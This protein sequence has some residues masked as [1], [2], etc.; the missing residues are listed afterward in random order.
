MY[1]TKF[2]AF[3][4]LI[5]LLSLPFLLLSQNNYV[6]NPSFDEISDCDLEFG[7]VP[8]AEPW[9]IVEEPG[10]SP[11]LYHAC[12]TNTFYDLP[13]FGSCYDVYPHSG[14]GMAA[15][16]HIAFN[17][18]IYVR[19]SDELPTGID[20]YVAFHTIPTHR[21]GAETICY[22]NTQCLAF[23]DIAF[24]DRRVALQM[25]TILD[26]ADG[27]TKVDGCYQANGKEKLLLIGNYKLGSETLVDCE[28]FDPNES[29]VYYFVDDVIVSPFDVVPDT[30][31]ICGDEVLEL[32]INFYELDILWEDGWKGGQRTITQGGQYTVIG[33]TESCFLKDS[34]IVIKIPE[35]TETFEL[36][37]CENGNTILE[38]PIPALWPNG[39]ISTTFEVDHS[40]TYIA[41]LLIDC[42]EGSKTIEYQVEEVPCLLDY[43]V[44]NAFSPNDDGFNDELEFFFKSE[45]DF[46]GTLVIFDRWGNQLFEQKNILPTDQIRWD[47]TFG[48]RQLPPSVYVWAFQYILAKDGRTRF[49]SGDALLV[50]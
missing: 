12:S 34:M 49:I 42:E 1:S 5:I 32:D 35:E 3:V 25:D 39:K 28:D 9:K 20:I 50:R 33:D 29:S 40:G 23:S 10:A 16:A 6:P 31:I 48:D 11:D 14:A 47:G 17:E 38:S 45:F 44:P 4:S 13:V 37:F 24:E 43:Y 26:F 8:K 21:C 22:S 19:L 27:W 30:M 18:R 7:D 2:Q 15:M 41:D 36:S 46:N